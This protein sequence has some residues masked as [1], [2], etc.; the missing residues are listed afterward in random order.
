MFRL[1]EKEN[2]TFAFPYYAYQFSY[3]DRYGHDYYLL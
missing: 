2:L 1:G 3:P